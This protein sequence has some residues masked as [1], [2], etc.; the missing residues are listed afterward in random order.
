MSQYL[1]HTDFAWG[2]RIQYPADWQKQPASLTSIHFYSPPENPGDVFRD[3][4][5]VSIDETIISLAEYMDFQLKRAQSMAP[6]VRFGPRTALTLANLPAEQIEMTGQLGPLLRNG[7]PEML[8]IR[9]LIVAV[10][11]EKCV[12]ALT[13]MAESRAYEKFLPE[14]QAML[15]SLELS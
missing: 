11:K 12:V 6:N 10:K 2:Y 4:V 9:C 1:M 8:P 3:Y 15:T 5:S 13:F 7:R 14:F